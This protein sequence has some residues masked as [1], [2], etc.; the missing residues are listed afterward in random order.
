MRAVPAR[1][2]L[3]LRADQPQQ[4]PR[5]QGV[6]PHHRGP[7]RLHPSDR[8]LSRRA[9]R[10]CP[11]ALR[12]HDAHQG[13]RTAS[14]TSRCC[15][16]ATSSRPAGRPPC[17]A[18]SSRP[19]RSRSGAAARSARWRSAAPILLG[20]KQVIAIDNV[21]ERLAMARGRRRH[22]INFDEES[23]VERLNELTGGKGPEKCIDAVGMEAHADG[24]ARCRLRP[25]QAGADAGDAT[26][27]TCCAR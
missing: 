22:T 18:T 23:V 16:S 1:Q 19:T 6:R 17:S 3:G 24:S 10:V 15:S 9:G 7:V 4:G 25:R 8:R 2:L 21:P 12:R 14:P 20:A 13:A 11:R 5:R 26:G 27:R